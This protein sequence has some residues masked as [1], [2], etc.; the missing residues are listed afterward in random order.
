[1]KKGWDNLNKKVIV[2]IAVI[3]VAVLA[4]WGYNEFL[5]PE[6]S[7]GDKE[8]TIQ[9]VN[10][11]ADVDES[12]TYQTDHEFLFALLEEHQEELGMEYQTSEYGEMITAM[13]NHTVDDAKQEYFHIYVNDED[14]TTGVSQIPLKDGDVY[15]FELANY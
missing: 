7:E 5:A 12:F 15:K 11:E 8:V 4:F 9:I 10:E 13:M 6:G 3:A 14:A 2:I 1:M